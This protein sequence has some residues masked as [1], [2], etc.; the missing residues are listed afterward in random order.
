MT[1]RLQHQRL[2]EIFPFRGGGKDLP[3]GFRRN[4]DA[5]G[6]A[7]P[8]PSPTSVRKS[9]RPE[10]VDREDRTF[11]HQPEQ[12][13]LVRGWRHVS[14]PRLSLRRTAGY[15]IQHTIKC[16]RIAPLSLPQHLDS[17]GPSSPGD[18]PGYVFSLFYGGLERV[19]PQAEKL[20]VGASWTRAPL[21]HGKHSRDLWNSS[22]RS[23]PPS[24]G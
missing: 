12:L 8:L 14:P 13:H 6:S 20:E 23:G 21:A 11:D 3:P 4:R 2:R 7:S 19:V 1:L 16:V 5:W 17:S 22:G 9:S 15:Q 24:W 18:V 10:T